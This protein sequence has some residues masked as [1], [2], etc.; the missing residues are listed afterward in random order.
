MLNQALPSAGNILFSFN[1]NY[2]YLLQ[3][4]EFKQIPSFTIQFSQPITKYSFSFVNEVKKISFLKKSV[5]EK[6]F[7][8]YAD[9]IKTFLKSA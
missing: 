1:F 6:R 9:F 4:K 5:K 7:A 8:L 3:S 2:E